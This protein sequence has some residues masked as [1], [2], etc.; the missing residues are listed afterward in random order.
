[1]PAARQLPLG[2][3][4]ISSAPARGANRAAEVR[5]ATTMKAAGGMIQ[6]RVTI[7][8][9]PM[10]RDEVVKTI[11]KLVEQSQLES[12]CLTCQLYADVAD[13]DAL[14]LLEE[15]SNRAEMERRMESAAFGQLLQLME[16]S[17]RPPEA[18]FHTIT[19]SSGLEAVQQVRMPD[20][21]SAT[22]GDGT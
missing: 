13:P 22:P 8:A 6:A 5:R 20:R 9:Q 12:G 2:G 14:T 15:W 11:R 7:Y 18:V 19:E 10:R 4:G 17:R 21:R 16:L 3:D 1:M